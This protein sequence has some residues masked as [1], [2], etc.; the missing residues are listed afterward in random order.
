MRSKS[1]AERLALKKPKVKA[2]GPWICRLFSLRKEHRLTISDV[3]K[4]TGLSMAC[5][6]FVE[7]GG[8]PQL[9]TVVLLSEF[10]GIGIKDMWPGKTKEI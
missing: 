4:G 9:T 2:K 1:P 10:F 6:W 5:V 7:H 3:A 8:D